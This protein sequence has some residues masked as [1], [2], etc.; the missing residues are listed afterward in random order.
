MN[1]YRSN[2]ARG[3]EKVKSVFPENLGILQMF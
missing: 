2:G 3:R 1:N